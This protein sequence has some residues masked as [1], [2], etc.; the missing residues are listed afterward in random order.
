MIR[1]LPSTTRHTM[2]LV[3]QGLDVPDPPDLSVPL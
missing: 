3:D 1:P 2:P